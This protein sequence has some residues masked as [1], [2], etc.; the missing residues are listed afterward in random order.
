MLDGDAHWLY[1]AKIHPSKACMA[2]A[3]AA[4]IAPLETSITPYILLDLER[5]G[6]VTLS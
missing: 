3:E 1:C 2:L 5:K 6:F 4:V